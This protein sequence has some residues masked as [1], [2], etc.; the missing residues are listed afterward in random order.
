L[1]G[2]DT[3]FHRFLSG[4]LSTAPLPEEEL[5]TLPTFVRFRWGDQA[6]YF[7]RR[8]WTRDSTGVA[9]LTRNE[10]GLAEAR[11]HLFGS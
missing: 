10:Q 1:L 11:R 6:D 7:A 2:D 9:N 8:I 4:Y 3:A 5:P